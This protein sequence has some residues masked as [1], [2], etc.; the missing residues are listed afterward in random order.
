M[1]EHEL[2]LAMTRHALEQIAA[3][4]HGDASSKSAPSKEALPNAGG[5]L[6]L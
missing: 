6:P 2:A 1:G 5:R 3:G 4:A